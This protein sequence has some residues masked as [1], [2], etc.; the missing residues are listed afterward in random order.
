MINIPDKLWYVIGYKREDNLAYMTY[1]KEDAAFEKRKTTGQDWAKPGYS[2]DYSTNPPTHI[3]PPNYDLKGTIIENSPMCGMY[4]GSSVSRWGTSNKL[5]RVKDP[6]NFTVEVP[7][8]NIATLLHLT[9]VK[10]GVV[11][12]ACVWGR[13][14]NSHIILPVNSDIYQETLGKM[15]ILKSGLISLKD[16]VVGGV[17]KQ[18]DS[19]AEVVYLG[20]VKSTWKVTPY[21][22]D[23]SGYRWSS[24]KKLHPT[25]EIVDEKW[26]HVFW[27]TNGWVVSQG[28]LEKLVRCLDSQ[29]LAKIRQE[30]TP[31]FPERVRNKV[32]ASYK[33]QGISNMEREVVS[34]Q[35]KD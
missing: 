34:K 11:E 5:F 24:T 33:G 17:Y 25:E 22:Y 15:E 2:Y 1:Y 29:E 21:Y 16:V 23:H 20:R 6:R 19:N 18:F 27:E 4:I 8:D 26:E 35:W 10:N 12:E 28:K 14:G 3:A 9:T 32:F 30:C 7:T 13:E 31:H